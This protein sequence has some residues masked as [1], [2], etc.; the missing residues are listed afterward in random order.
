MDS[1]LK[2]LNDNSNKPTADDVETAIEAD[3]TLTC[4]SKKCKFNEKNEI[5]HTKK[6]TYNESFLQVSLSYRKTVNTI[7]FV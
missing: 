6:K 2:K 5:S 3:T 4:T 1:L 7:H